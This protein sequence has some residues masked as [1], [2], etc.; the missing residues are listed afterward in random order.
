M[1]QGEAIGGIGLTEPRSGSDLA[2]LQTRAVRTPEG[3]RI[4]GAKTFITNGCI[5]DL[6]LVAAKTAPERGAKGISLFLVETTRPGFRRGRKLKKI[7]NHAQDTT[8]LFFDS[9]ELPADALLGGVE[10]EGWRQLMH[11]LAQERMVVA[12]RS[13][14]MAE[15]AFD[16]TLAYVRERKA[17]GGRIADFQNT[18]FKLAE[19]ATEIEVGRPF[20]DRC[21]A[22]LAENRLSADIAAKAKLWTTELADRVLDECLQLHGGYGYMWEFPI[23]RAWADAR[24]H[25]IYAGTNEV[26]KHI[27]S[28]RY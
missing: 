7:G 25:R 18:R 1:A 4:D 10:N 6:I 14:A 24:V 16:Q 23:A 8:E 21:I 5:A 13:L 17:F 20:V 15:A 12:V 3:Y 2:G 28:R 11:G 26:M 27:I 19:V 22:L 9:L